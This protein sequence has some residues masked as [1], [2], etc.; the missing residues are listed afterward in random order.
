MTKVYCFFYSLFFIWGCPDFS[1]FLKIIFAEYRIWV[2]SSFYSW[3][4]LC[5]FFVA[6]MISDKKSSVIQIVFL[7]VDKVFVSC[8]F[9]HFCPLFRFTVMCYGIN[10]FGFILLWILYAT[11]FCRFISSAKFGIFSALIYLNS[12]STVPS[13]SFP[14]MTLITQMI[15]LFCYSPTGPW[16]SWCWCLGSWCSCMLITISYSVWDHLG[17]CFDEWFFYW[18]VEYYVLRLW[19]I[20]TSSW[21]WK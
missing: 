17:S 7:S 1:S 4:M 6:S 13:F 3:K 15:G 12:F 2:N 9:Q 16:G 11:W 20:V 21:C 5:H 8:C 14:F 10:F 18:N 19:M